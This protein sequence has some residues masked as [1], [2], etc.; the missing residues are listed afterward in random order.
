MKRRFS[1]RSWSPSRTAS[2]R[3]MPEQAARLAPRLGLKLVPGLKVLRQARPKEKQARQAKLALKEPVPK[4][5]PQR[6]APREMAKLLLELR[7]KPPLEKT[8]TATAREERATP[9]EERPLPEPRAKP[10]LRAKLARRKV[11]PRAALPVPRVRVPPVKARLPPRLPREVSPSR[12]LPT[13]P[14]RVPKVSLIFA[15]DCSR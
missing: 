11:K 13:R 3:S 10:A 12:L 7:A 8:A 5:E 1:M 9:K 2:P 4:A 14:R 15:L 6:V